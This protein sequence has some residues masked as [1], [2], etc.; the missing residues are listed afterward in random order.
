LGGSVGEAVG[1]PGA[2]A[3]AGVGSAVG[4][5][6]GAGAGAGAGGMGLLPSFGGLTTFGLRI[7]WI[8]GIALNL[9]SAAAPARTS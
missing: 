7:T 4:P 9:A 8:S 6:A 2:G 5:V 3:G 1:V